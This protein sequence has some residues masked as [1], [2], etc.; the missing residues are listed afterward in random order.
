[1]TTTYPAAWAALRTRAATEIA[2][3]VF[4]QFE[5]NRLPDVPETFA[6]VEM[7][8]ERAGFIEIGGGRGANRHRHEAELNLYVFVPIGR[9]MQAALD[10][11]E[12]V[13]SVFR[14]FRQSGVSCDG[15]E[16][17]PVGQGA[18]LVP[19]GLSSAAGNY[20]CVVVSVPVHF[21][22]LA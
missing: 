2:V 3:P 20:C 12:P 14:S 4:W 8:T 7:I 5:D 10:A 15:A 16:I 22:Q 21:D 6:Y 1:M 17:H 11:A 19:P 9:G 18:E 13:A